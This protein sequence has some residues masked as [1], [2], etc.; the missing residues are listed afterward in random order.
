MAEII[1]DDT[2]TELASSPLLLCIQQKRYRL[3]YTEKKNN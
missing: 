2:V 1:R 3:G